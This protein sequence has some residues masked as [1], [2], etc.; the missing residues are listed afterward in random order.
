LVR[1]LG[2]GD[3]IHDLEDGHFSSLTFSPAGL[4]TIAA[5]AGEPFMVDV[6]PQAAPGAGNVTVG[7]GHDAAADED[8][9]GPFA[10]TVQ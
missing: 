6:T 9:F 7:Y 2:D 5:V 1:I 4:A 8:S 10:V 3:H